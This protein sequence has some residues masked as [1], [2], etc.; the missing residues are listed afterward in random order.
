[1]RFAEVWSEGPALLHEA[2]GRACPD[3]IADESDVVSL[4]T[5]LFLRPEAE[6]DPAW[7]L[8]Q[9]SNHFGPETGYRQSVVD[10][11]QLAKAVQQTIRLHKRGGQEY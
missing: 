7:T 8:E 9:I 6:R 1:M 5:L 2:I 10:L 3:L 11:P 4:S